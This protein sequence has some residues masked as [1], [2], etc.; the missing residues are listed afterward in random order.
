MYILLP[1]SDPAGLGALHGKALKSYEIRKFCE[2]DLTC[3]YDKK[4]TTVI[5]L[6]NYTIF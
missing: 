1:G 2:Y 6:R 4:N 5:D 3:L